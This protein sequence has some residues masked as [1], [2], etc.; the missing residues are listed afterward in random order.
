MGVEI[1]CVGRGS[2]PQ[3]SPLRMLEAALTILGVVTENLS[4]TATGTEV[5][6][7]HFRTGLLKG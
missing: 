2:Y 3:K 1:L 6:I 7:R 4:C 5:S